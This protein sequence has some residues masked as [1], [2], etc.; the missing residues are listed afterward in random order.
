M[1]GLTGA[2]PSPPHSPLLGAPQRA[3]SRV[4]CVLRRSS[5]PAT[6]TNSAG[7]CRTSTGRSTWSL[8][9]GPG[10]FPV[11]EGV[12]LWTVSALPRSAHVHLPPALPPPEDQPRHRASEWAASGHGSKPASRFALSLVRRRRGGSG[13]TTT[14][15]SVP[16]PSPARPTWSAT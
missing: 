11:C 7:T 15:S 1:A 4:L 3:G 9:V 12:T 2:E 10:W 5:K 14:A 16:S 6:A 8:K 13:P